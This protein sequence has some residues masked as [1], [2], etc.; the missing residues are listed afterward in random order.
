MSESPE[1]KAKNRKKV[2]TGLLLTLIVF[3][4]FLFYFI[5]HI[6]DKP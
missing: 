2:L 3:A 5:S 4:W 6:P 1:E